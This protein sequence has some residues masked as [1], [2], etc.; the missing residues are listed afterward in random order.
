MT[1]TKTQSRVVVGVFMTALVALALASCSSDDAKKKV[2]VPPGEAGEGGEAGAS[3]GGAGGVAAQSG[4][5]GAN[6]AGALAI[7]G[8]SGESGAAAGGAGTAGALGAS[9]EGGAVAAGGTSAEGGASGATCDSP[10]TGRITIAF[11]S[12]DAERVT[13]LQWL[14]SA[15]VLTANLI[16]Q[17]GPAWCNDPQEFF[18]QSYG[19]PEGTAPG[20]VVGGNLATLVQCGLDATI[21]SAAVGCSPVAAQMPVTTN[22]HFYGDARASELRITRTVGFG[23]STAP[24]ANTV[25]LRPYVPRVPLSVFP[26]VIYPNQAGTAVASAAASSCGGDCIV[27]VGATWNGEWFADIASSGLA[28][29]VLRDPAMTT[30]VSFTV[31]N[32]SSSSS[33]LTSFVVLQPTGGWKAPVT[34]TEYL[35]FA[36]LTSWP[37]T[38][39]DAATL[40]AGCGP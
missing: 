15:S 19:A 30:P 21:T 26:T 11:D 1:S 5:A 2:F 16:A 13:N 12:A 9:G 37:Q 29:I 7:G 40:P 27:P 23:A 6:L 33:N 8:E 3:V 36:D 28:L 17:G 34:E 22:Y 38:A 24:Y 32:D 35:C 31:N 4:E 10:A 14:N 18:G 20:P 39:R 25:G